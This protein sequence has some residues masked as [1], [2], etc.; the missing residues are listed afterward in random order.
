MDS[1]LRRPR[2]VYYD[3]EIRE[4]PSLDSS[5]PEQAP[6]ASVQ[7]LV[8]QAPPASSEAFKHSDQDGG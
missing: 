6:L 2:S 4:L 1:N 3:P 7:P 8:D 5:H